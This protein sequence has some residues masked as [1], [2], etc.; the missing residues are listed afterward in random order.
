MK[1]ER[2]KFKGKLIFAQKLNKYFISAF[3]K[4]Y[5]VRKDREILMAKGK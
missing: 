3:G 4:A 2:L 5:A 1:L